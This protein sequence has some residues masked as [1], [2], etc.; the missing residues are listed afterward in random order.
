MI[1]FGFCHGI[2]LCLISI[3]SMPVNATAQSDFNAGIS[4]FGKADYDKAL[5]YFKKAESAGLDTTQLTYNLGSVYYKLGRYDLSKSYFNSLLSNPALSFQAQ[6]SL[7]LI[8][9]RTGNIDAAI[10][11][12]EQSIELTDDAK[13]KALALRQ[14][15]ILSN[16]EQK[17]TA[18]K[19]W[20]LYLS[21]AYGHDSNITHT[22]S[23]D[24]SDL[25][26]TFLQL[27]LYGDLEVY[28]PGK[29]SIHAMLTHFSRDYDEHS[30]FNL[31]T[32]VLGTEYRQRSENW[33]LTYG[34]DLGRSSFSGDD[35]LASNAFKFS[36]KRILT[37]ENELRIN[38]NFE[39][40]DSLS[41]QY[42]FLN[43][44]RSQLKTEYRTR[45]NQQELSYIY[46]LELNDRE[47]TDTQNFS[48]TRHLIGL[49]YF[50]RFNAE[51]KGGVK[52]DYRD[53][54]YDSTA[55]QN[56]RDKRTR[57]DIVGIYQLTSNWSVKID[58]LFTRNRSSEEVYDYRS[59]LATL[60]LN[61]LF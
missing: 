10:R 43:G 6:Y 24:A 36:A 25:S 51:F 32:T 55:V 29:D 13:L 16:A 15:Q 23:S 39:K 26:G 53:S 1:K 52:L 33:N 21:P 31:S 54:D 18:V 4:A 40:L 38:L 27:L 11:L 12:F 60:S 37:D 45:P 14:I 50:H 8:E 57:L 35:Y 44:K 19:P 30:D 49:N 28:Q 17:Q 58:I 61:R 46:L 9:H 42:D 7:A 2:V 20:F 5:I 41:S 3:L 34:V 47:D 48:P 22:P 56:R 59:R